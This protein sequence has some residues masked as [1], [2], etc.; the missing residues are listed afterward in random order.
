MFR[1]IQ[2][3]VCHVNNHRFKLSLIL[4][5]PDQ[6]DTSRSTR[7]FCRDQF[8]VMSLSCRRKIG[9]YRRRWHNC[10]TVVVCAQIFINYRTVRVV[11]AANSNNVVH[12]RLA[13]M[14]SIFIRGT[15]LWF[16][17]NVYVDR[18]MVATVPHTAPGHQYI[19]VQTDLFVPIRQ[20]KNQSPLVNGVVCTLLPLLFVSGQPTR[21]RFRFPMFF[22][23]QH[24]MTV[25]LC[26][27]RCSGDGKKHTRVHA[28]SCFT[29]FNFTV[30]HKQAFI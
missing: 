24:G 1:Y 19:S 26:E 29:Y 16:W 22:F 13:I 11:A 7:Y 3:H 27:E 9:V 25:C 4:L 18:M 30:M 6:R 15:D 23:A 20:R 14:Q 21:P 8:I 28:E 12:K 5:L 17:N 2:Y 10:Q